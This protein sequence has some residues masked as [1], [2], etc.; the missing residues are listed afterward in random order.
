MKNKFENAGITLI[1]LV[2]TVVVLLILAGISL[3]L[4]IG[5]NGIINRAKEARDRTI[6]AQQKED[7]ELSYIETIISASTNKSQEELTDIIKDVILKLNLRGIYKIQVTI[8]QDNGTGKFVLDCIR[9]DNGT[10][11][12]TDTGFLADIG[13]GSEMN[14]R[15]IIVENPRQV[16]KINDESMLL[17]LIF[18]NQIEGKTELPEEIEMLDEVTLKYKDEIYNIVKFQSSNVIEIYL[19]NIKTVNIADGTWK[20]VIMDEYGTSAMAIDENDDLYLFAKDVGNRNQLIGTVTPQRVMENVAEVVTYDCDYYIKTMDG[21]WYIY[22]DYNNVKE[23]SGLDIMQIKQF[24]R[25]KIL[26][27]EGTLWEVSY[28][29][30]IN[31]I[32]QDVKFNKILCVSNYCALYEDFDGNIWLDNQNITEQ[33]YDIQAKDI[34]NFHKSSNYLS[35][36]YQDGELQIFDTNKQNIW[37]NGKVRSISCFSYDEYLIACENNSVYMLD[38]TWDNG[39]EPIKEI[40]NNLNVK[41]I[42][43]R[44]VIDANNYIWMLSKDNVLVK[45]TEEFSGRKI[46]SITC[47]NNSKLIG[48]IIITEDGIMHTIGYFMSG[49]A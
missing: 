41:I 44:Y 16:S 2:V 12:R 7:L 35:I 31:S 22:N 40:C 29:G 18:D 20:Y 46:N 13:N 36:M 14:I 39:E 38:D 37:E 19:Q 9:E 11:Y 3:N 25:G 6:A 30:T 45:C 49:L 27:E 32:N 5:Q 42:D 24:V 34:A 33:G 1:A 43:G 17:Y 4:V 23:I 28:D 48:I 15:D 26:D 10:L 47:S 21:K 8:D